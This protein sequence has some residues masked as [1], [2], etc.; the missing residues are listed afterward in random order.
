MAPIF[1][2]CGVSLIFMGSDNPATP[3]FL[4]KAR[5]RLMRSIFRGQPSNE[6][7]LAKVIEQASQDDI[8]NEDTEDMIRG[9]F[10]ITKRRITDIM[11]PRSQIVAIDM[12]CTIAAAI[13]TISESGHSRYPVSLEDKDHIQGILMA[14]DLLPIASESDK[15]IADYQHLLR[16]PVVVPESKRVDAMLKDFQKNRFHMAIVID[17][18]GGVC[19]LVTIEDILELIVGE[20]NDEYEQEESSKDIVK[21]GENTY[22]VDGSTSIEDFTQYFH[23]QLP[24]IDVDTIAGLVIHSLGHIPHKDESTTINEFTFKVVSSNHH[25]VHQLLVTV[26]PPAAES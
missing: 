26:N 14:K 23:T 5:E 13:K 1:S 9:V 16:K 10:A 6:K 2:H 4:S 17:E 25:Q 19:G 3:S 12:D 24:S 7:E 8:I 15:R 21:T 18:Y 20:I 11:I 22:T